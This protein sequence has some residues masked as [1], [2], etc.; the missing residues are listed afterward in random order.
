MWYTHWQCQFQSMNGTQYAV[1]ICK[2]TARV[3]DIVQ[4]TGAAQTFSTQ[5]DDS[6]DIFT[7]IRTQTGYLRV[8]DT[9]GTLLANLIPANNTE[10]LVQ[11]W[12]GSNSGG[13]F[14][15]HALC[16]QGFLQA[17]AYTQPWDN[18]ASVLE[19]PVKSLLGALQDVSIDETFASTEQN[20]AALIL[21]AFDNFG[22]RADNDLTHLIIT[23]DV[24]DAPNTLLKPFIQMSV[25][26][27]KETVN[28]QGD[29]YEQLVCQSYYEALSAVMSLY[30]L[31][32]REDGTK[33]YMNQ[34]DGLDVKVW[35]IGWGYL[36]YIAGGSSIVVTPTVL[37]S[38]DMLPALTFKG[39]DNIAG[40]SQGGRSAKVTLNFEHINENILSLPMTTEDSTEPHTIEKVVNGT[41]KV[42]NHQ[43]ENSSTE[44]FVLRKYA[45]S[46][47]I[48][49]QATYNECVNGSVIG[50]PIMPPV[51]DDPS[52]VTGAFPV[53]Y[54]YNT[55]DDQT[56][57]FLTNGLMVNIRRLLSYTDT[58][59]LN[60]MS[61]YQIKSVLVPTFAKG[62]LNIEINM[63]CFMQTNATQANKRLQFGTSGY[64]YTRRYKIWL[65]LQW[66]TK[67]WNGEAWTTDGNS[68]F[69]VETDGAKIVTNI[70]DNI[71]SDKSDGFFIPIT[72]VM[73]GQVSLSIM[74]YGAFQVTYPNDTT[75]MFQVN[76]S[77]ISHLQ[78]TYLAPVGETVSSRTSNVYRRTILQSGFSENKEIDITL[79]TINNNVESL[80]F[81]KQNLTTYIEKFSYIDANA[82][83]NQRPEL[84]LLGRM[85]DHYG[86]VRR[87]LRGIVQRGVELMQTSYGYRGR[88]YF[89]V[90]AA[91]EWRDDTEEV[92]FIEV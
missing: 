77:I 28:N 45:N 39:A 78:I 53:R 46:S 57:K 9:D 82:T 81:I 7:P 20:V 44:T 24:S 13:T 91:T 4:L 47:R 90:K 71:F 25:F 76:S 66:G 14:T 30:G 83:I 37:P 19:L 63:S 56:Q 58:L 65:Q 88:L 16:W 72:E 89:G 31:Q 86:Q 69:P 12:S 18:N 2:Q 50:T 61:V 75:E 79:G 68:T 17:E 40:Y 42:Q 73:S 11:L 43:R 41:V 10:R 59:P 23:A 1:N 52:Y 8:I 64:S 15:P 6:D 85:V 49:T 36:T 3:G 29:S 70:S 92:K 80:S 22:L 51:T 87:M 32:L 74:N 67:Y 27:D 34:F 62:Y 60:F 33:I 84:H 5:E 54:S 35:S 55:P 26:F 48:S 21:A 38:V